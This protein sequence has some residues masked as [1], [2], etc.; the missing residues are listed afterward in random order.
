[1]IHSSLLL[2]KLVYLFSL[3]FVNQV[4]IYIIYIVIKWRKIVDSVPITEEGAS[5]RLLFEGVRRGAHNFYSK[6]T[7]WEVS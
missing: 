3:I 5:I 4:G 7:E 1:M 6:D 2:Q